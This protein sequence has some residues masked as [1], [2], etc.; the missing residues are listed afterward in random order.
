VPRQAARNALD[1]APLVP[2]SRIRDRAIEVWT[3]VC[4]LVLALSPV[5][6]GALVGVWDW[7]AIF[8]FKLAFAADAA[9][10]PEN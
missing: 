3:A 4:G 7:R 5:I 2:G 8:W 9:V 1:P 10:L 6:G